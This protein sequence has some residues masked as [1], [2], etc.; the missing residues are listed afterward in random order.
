MR[1]FLILSIS[2]LM[3]TT[4]G[5]AQSLQDQYPLL[6]CDN[7]EI[8]RSLVVANET[9][10]NKDGKL[11]MFQLIEA[12]DKAF[13]PVL[14]SVV[15]GKRYALNVSVDPAYKKLDLAVIDGEQTEIVK[16]TSRNRK[17]DRSVSRQVFTAKETGHYWLVLNLASGKKASNCVGIG[18]IE[19][20]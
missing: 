3:L 14:I 8:H 12:P 18:I 17:G 6:P 20:N 10:L 4:Q 7:D 19:L 2:I 1:T 11:T 13:V 15:E 16:H 5:N 9:H